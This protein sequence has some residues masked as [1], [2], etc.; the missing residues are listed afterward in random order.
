M[1]LRQ[2]NRYFIGLRSGLWKN[3]ADFLLL[4]PNKDEQK[5]LSEL[6]KYQSN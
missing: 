6:E 4:I 1:K 5:K 3:Q 2:W